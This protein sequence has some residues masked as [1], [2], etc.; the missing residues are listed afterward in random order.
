MFLNLKPTW[1]VIIAG[2]I[3]MGVLTGMDKMTVEA[4]TEFTKWGITVG[5]GKSAIVEGAIALKNGG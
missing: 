2:I 3:A 1:W 5:A 4:F